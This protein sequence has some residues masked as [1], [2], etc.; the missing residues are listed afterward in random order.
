[1]PYF[2]PIAEEIHFT[3]EELNAI[4]VMQACS[5][6]RRQRLDVKSPGDAAID[7]SIA[8]AQDVIWAMLGESTGKRKEK[9]N[10]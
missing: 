9:E 8:D 1:M 6:Y 2:E 5:G 4:I 10:A 3:E 7:K